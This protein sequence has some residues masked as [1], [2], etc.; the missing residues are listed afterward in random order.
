MFH[1]VLVALHI[2]A[3]EADSVNVSEKGSVLV[4]FF[5]CSDWFLGNTDVCFGVGFINTV[6]LL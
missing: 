6:G 2:P 5:L 4:I 3:F 1:S